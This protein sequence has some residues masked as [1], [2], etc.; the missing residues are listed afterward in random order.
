[1]LSEQQPASLSPLTFLTC[2]ATRAASVKASFTPRFFIA[3]HSV[4]GSRQNRGQKEICLPKYLKAL[5]FSATAKPCLS[6]LSATSTNR[7]PGQFSAISPTHLLSTFS[8]E[9]GLSTLKQSMIAWVS[10]YDKE[11]RRSNSSCPAVSQSES[12][13]WVL[14]IKMSWTYW[15]V[16]S[17]EDIEE[18]CLAACT[19][20]AE[21]RIIKRHLAETQYATPV[22]RPLKGG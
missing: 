6:H 12:S 7:T 16:A 20:A 9:S 3:E 10:S 15:E 18:G 2:K 8:S 21:S 14:S 1:M 22:M 13:T 11:R 5:T 4:Q 17:G 19:V